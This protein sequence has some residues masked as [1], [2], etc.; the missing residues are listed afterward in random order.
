MTSI[1]VLSQLSMMVF[2]CFLVKH[3]RGIKTF[4]MG[5]A[6]AA[7]G[8]ACVFSLQPTSL[9]VYMGSCL[10]VLSNSICCLGIARFIGKKLKPFYLVLYNL[11]FIFIQ[12][13][14]ILFDDRFLY[15]IIVHTVF[16]SILMFLQFFLL[17]SSSHEGFFES[18]RFLMTLYFCMGWI[19]LLRMVGLLRN[20]PANFFTPNEVNAGSLLVAFVFTLLL[21]IGFT[22][23]V[24]QRLYNS[25]QVTADTDELT[26]LLNRRAMMQLLT[27]Q[28]KRYLQRGQSFALLLID[29]DHF[30][31][32]NDR[33]GHDGGD[34]VLIHLAQIFKKQSRPEEFTSRWG[35]EEFLVL[36][37]NTNRQ[38]A[39][40]RAEALRDYVEQTPTPSGIQVT[41]SLGVSLAQSTFDSVE[42]LITAAD[43]ALYAAKRSDETE[44]GQAEPAPHHFNLVASQPLDVLWLP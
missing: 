25:L 1:S 36:L 12:T 6:M 26:G 27:Q 4:T 38:E 41:M 3:Y 35:G 29:V 31:R 15:K 22:M 19:F 17:C 16:Q 23:M 13:Y 7:L 43:H 8:Y 44:S 14:L 34:L 11:S 20:L 30:K 24:C 10:L 39:L 32:I 28:M 5:R 21:T 33:Y 42:S 37:P 9:A 18:K 2:L 40:A